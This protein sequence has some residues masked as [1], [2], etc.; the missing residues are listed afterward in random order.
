[1]TGGTLQPTR[2]QSISLMRHTAEFTCRLSRSVNGGNGH[3]TI[4]DVGTP[5]Q[6]RAYFIRACGWS[7][8]LGS[9]S[10]WSPAALNIG[11]ATNVGVERELR[12]GRTTKSSF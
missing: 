8:P 6:F 11:R 1:G 2:P 5:R 7:L 9:G 12:I 3:L 10:L 4:G